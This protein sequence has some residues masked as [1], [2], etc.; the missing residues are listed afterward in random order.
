[1]WKPDREEQRYCWGCS[2]WFNTSCIQYHART[3]SSVAAEQK[4]FKSHEG[5]AEIIVD[6]AFQP[7]AR[8]GPTHFASGNGRIVRLARELLNDANLDSYP[9]YVG[10]LLEAEGDPAFSRENAWAEIMEDLIGLK[11]AHRGDFSHEQLI[12]REQQMYGCPICE[13]IV[14]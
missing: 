12:C 3:Q 9:Q 1:V 8:G 11:K 4:A 2:N 5:Y 14:L 6:V 7:T 13:N 10:H